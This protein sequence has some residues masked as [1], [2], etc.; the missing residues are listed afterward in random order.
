MLPTPSALVKAKFT[1]TVL[2]RSAMVFEICP[3]Y[4]ARPRGEKIFFLIENFPIPGKFFLKNLFWRVEE[5]EEKD[6]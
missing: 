6:D 3:Y 2:Q 4:N 5:E 1:A